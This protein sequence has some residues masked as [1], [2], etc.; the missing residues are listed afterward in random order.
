MSASVRMSRVQSGP[1]CIPQCHAEKED[2]QNRR[3]GL[4]GIS[5]ENLDLSHP[6][7]LI[8]NSRDAGEEENAEY[9]QP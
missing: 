1:R 9:K 3:S 4:R 5:E 7:D 6:E 8:D 2:E